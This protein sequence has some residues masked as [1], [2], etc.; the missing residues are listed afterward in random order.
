MIPAMFKE[1]YA[2]VTVCKIVEK[3]WEEQDK[4]KR[5]HGFI[6]FVCVCVSQEF[7]NKCEKL[8]FNLI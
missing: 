7:G 2:K 8:I 6:F 4:R 5:G 3:E 1:V